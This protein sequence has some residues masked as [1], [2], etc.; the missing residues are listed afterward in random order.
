MTP[1]PTVTARI[2]IV[3]NLGGVFGQSALVEGSVP[4]SRS[5]PAGRVISVGLA[6]GY[7]HTEAT[8]TGI[9]PIGLM[10][11]AMTAAVPAETLALHANV[12]LLPLLACLRARLPLRLPV[13]IA[14]MGL[15]GATWATSEITNQN[16]GS[17]FSRAAT[18]G[19]AA[20]GGTE[21]ALPLPP[22]ELILGLR[23][24]W[25]GAARLSNGD[26][27]PGNLGGLLADVGYRLRL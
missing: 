2:G 3:S 27:L 8:A 16:D 24:L 11:P 20:G 13:E 15:A 4:W 21:A 26:A 25:L 6:A 23:Y 1:G 10:T 14:L 22:G 12:S 9:S 5:R 19:L 18:T 17:V 7:L